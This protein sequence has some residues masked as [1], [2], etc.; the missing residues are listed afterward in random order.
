MF[1]PVEIMKAK[2]I[3]EKECFTPA[4]IF[5]SASFPIVNPVKSPCINNKYKKEFDNSWAV[6]LTA[7][8]NGAKTVCAM[9]RKGVM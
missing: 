8:C 5:P 1:A 7:P 2:N 4:F 3:S 6:S 9:F